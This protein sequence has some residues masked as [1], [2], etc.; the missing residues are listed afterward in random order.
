MSLIIFQLIEKTP[1]GYQKPDGTFHDQ[2][3]TKRIVPEYTFYDPENGP[4]TYRH[5]RNESTLVK[6]KQTAT[7]MTFADNLFFT[8]SFMVFDSD[9]DSISIEFAR[10]HPNNKDFKGKVKP[11]VRKTFEEVKENQLKSNEVDLHKEYYE[12]QRIIFEAS[13]E[14]GEFQLLCMT[15]KVS[16]LDIS[17]AQTE[18]LKI[19]GKNSKDFIQSAHE[20]ISTIK[21]N[22]KY[23]IES[24]KVTFSDGKIKI[25]ELTSID[26]K[27]GNEMPTLYKH[28]ASPIGDEHYKKLS[29]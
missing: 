26:V 16:T 23:F 8:N 24:K 6:N 22:I 21:E 20:G 28:F 4:V 11:G 2:P 10:K 17:V 29:L 9:V 3:T 7:E 15:F 27:T 25:A 19:A 12:A 13:P 1:T 18:L 5:I 14:T